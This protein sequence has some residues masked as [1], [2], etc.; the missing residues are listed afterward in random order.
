MTPMETN[1]LR[2]SLPDAAA[3]LPHAGSFAALAVLEVLS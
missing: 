2:L 1:P 3:T